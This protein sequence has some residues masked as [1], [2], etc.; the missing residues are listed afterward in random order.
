MDGPEALNSGLG[1]GTG[2]VVYLDYFDTLT[3]QKTDL[4]VD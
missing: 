1:I 4:S 2:K 3:V